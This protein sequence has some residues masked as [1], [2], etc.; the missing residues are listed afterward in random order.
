MSLNLS[1]KWRM[2]MK[3]VLQSKWKSGL[4]AVSE[5]HKLYK[6]MH[7]FAYTLPKLHMTHTIYEY[8]NSYLY[9]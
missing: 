7:F 1:L 9:P 8:A 6:F 4:Q 2:K 5:R 3:L